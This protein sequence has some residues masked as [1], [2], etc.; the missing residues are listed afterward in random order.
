MKNGKRIGLIAVSAVVIAVVVGCGVGMFVGHNKP[1]AQ[2]TIQPI[3]ADDYENSDAWGANYPAQYETWKA[4]AESTEQPS[5]FEDMP[6]L[7]NM[8]A[9]I[10]YAF[11][12]GHPRGHAHMLEDIRKVDP[13]RW[14]GHQAACWTCKSTQI[15]GLVEKYGDD[16]FK[17]SWEEIGEQIDQTVGCYNCHDPETMDLRVSQPPLIEAFK[18][19]GIDVN[20]ASRQEMRTLVCAQCHVSYYFP[21]DTNKT[22]FPWDE[23]L[24][25]ASQLKYYDKINFTEFVQDGTGTPMVKA[26]HQE[27]EYFKGSVHES[28]GVSCADCHMPYMKEGNQK[29]STHKVGSPLDTINQ[30]CMTCHREGES[31]LRSQVDNIQTT[32]KAQCDR[33]GEVSDR[34]I[35]ILT[36]ANNTPNIDKEKLKEAQRLHRYGQYYLDCVMITNGNGFHNPQRSLADLS[37]GMNYL[38]EAS[39]VANRAILA[40]D[41]KLPDYSDSLVDSVKDTPDYWEKL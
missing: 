40:A 38:N 30:S 11:E 29:I 28:A 23:G 12:F 16:F 24:D 4:T 2:T 10:G 26:R 33:A 27:Y 31:W 39:T 20:N 17:M 34:T 21:T 6:Y 14:Q 22:T 13:R 9:G 8:Y 25:V 18:R 1:L 36:E 37:T 7:K 19:Q 5:R 35:A 32:W 41:G 15:P 3:S